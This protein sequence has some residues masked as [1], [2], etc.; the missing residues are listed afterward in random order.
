MENEKALCADPGPT[1]RLLLRANVTS[2]RASNSANIAMDGARLQFLFIDSN[3]CVCEM[4][5][6]PQERP[7]QRR[8][9]GAVHDGTEIV[10]VALLP[11]CSGGQDEQQ[12]DHFGPEASPR[13]ASAFSHGN[14]GR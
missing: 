7:W 2:S 13:N 11:G 14:P 3:R 8:D 4:R 5:C 12:C 10:F 6:L 9:L 1:R